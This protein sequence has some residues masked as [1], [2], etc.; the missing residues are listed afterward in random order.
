MC[1][2]VSWWKLVG[3]GGSVSFLR[4]V[5]GKAMVKPSEE[6]KQ[7]IIIRVVCVGEGVYTWNDSPTADLQATF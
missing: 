4:E 1:V 2:C 5:E 3:G 7:I 6:D